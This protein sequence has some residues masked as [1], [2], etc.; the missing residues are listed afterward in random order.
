MVNDE[1][2]DGGTAISLLKVLPAKFGQVLII[3]NKV[4]YK[5]KP[6]Y[7]GFDSFSYIITKNAETDTALVTIELRN[8]NN[9]PEVVNDTVSLAESYN[10]V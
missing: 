10:F 9:I 3:G 6:Y 5:A 8:I 7:V 1:N 4:Q 2:V